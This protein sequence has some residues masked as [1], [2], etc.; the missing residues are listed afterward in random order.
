MTKKFEQTLIFGHRGSKGTHPENTM[1]SF[2]ESYRAGAEGIELDV[3]L[4]KD[5]IPVII[6]DESVDRTTNG[7][8][9]VKD[10][11]V[12]EL[13]SLDAGSWY[14]DKFKDVSIP[15]L[16]EVLEWLKTTPLVVNIELKN[17]MFP[18]PNLEEITLDLVRQFELEKRVI[19][20]SFN[21][22]SLFKVHQLQ[23]EIETAI[24]FMEGLYE[25]WNYAKSI[26]ASG[27][28]CH[29]HVAVPEIVAGAVKAGAPVRPFT[30]N[31]DAKIEALIRS[32]CSAI[33][34]DFPEK[35]VLL[36]GSMEWD[37]LGAK[38]EA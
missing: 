13:K 7:K 26:G 27:L 28:H 22:Y 8:G 32:G 16:Y 2:L 29:Y 1:P 24:L 38:L 21:H 35:A 31:D 25:P 3:Q 15:T 12:D 11:T 5:G 36:R 23:P 37:S 10:F 30:V 20:S 34:T 17:G 14:S 19:I 4:S 9:W 6:H 33:I 18:Y